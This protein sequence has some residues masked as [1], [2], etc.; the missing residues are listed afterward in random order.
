MAQ[1]L[2][3]GPPTLSPARRIEED[4]R[5]K[6][7]DGHWPVGMM[8][9]S[10]RALAKEYAV[11]LMAVQRA[12]TPLLAD[13]TLRADG[14]R[15]TFV[16]HAGQ[17][18][19]TRQ[20]PVGTVTVGIAASL[21]PPQVEG[22]RPVY[23]TEIIANAVERAVSEAGGATRLFNLYDPDKPLVPADKAAAALLENAGVDAIIVVQDYTEAQAGRLLARQ[24]LRRTPVVFVGDGDLRQPVPLVSYDSRDAGRDAARH[25]LAAGCLELLFFAP[26]SGPWVDL[27]LEGASEAVALSG[28][29]PDALRVL[30]ESR[31]SCDLM[32]LNGDNHGAQTVCALESAGVFLAHNSL[33]AGVIAVNDN[34][35]LGF[36][37]AAA[38]RG[39]EAGRDYALIGFDNVPLARRLGLSTMQPP[40]ESMGREAVR[41]LL[42]ALAGETASRRVFLHSHLIARPS[43]RFSNAGK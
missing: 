8:L 38:A 14:G 9:P 39:W 1:T 12:I 28:L 17:P 19:V 5:E 34:A 23:W 43:S 25:L 13:G 36:Q 27:R 18:A 32:P 10:R 21:H 31:P 11:D 42:A 24:D 30:A 4:L 40:L 26:Y 16:A 29:P 15:G 33:P 35:A 3:T 6:L 37:Q 20:R 7:R 41:L 2:K 22:E